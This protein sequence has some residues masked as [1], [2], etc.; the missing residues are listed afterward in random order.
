[1]LSRLLL[2]VF[3]FLLFSFL[4]SFFV[5]N[6]IMYLVRQ[7]NVP[8][9]AVSP[10]CPIYTKRKNQVSEQTDEKV[11]MV[12]NGALESVSTLRSSLVDS[13]NASLGSCF[14]SFFF[15]SVLLF[16]FFRLVVF[17]VFF[18]L[19]FFGFLVF[20]SFLFVCFLVCSLPALLFFFQVFFFLLSFISLFLLLR[21]H[22]LL[23]FFICSSC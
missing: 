8:L 10:S 4:F 20:L 19:F 6:P 7:L 15:H 22:L 5:G 12:W 17:F 18:P 11:D 2:S 1:M 13:E 9:H 14:L 23:L 3:F 21:I 16:F